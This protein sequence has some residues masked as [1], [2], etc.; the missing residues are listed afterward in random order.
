M[1]KVSLRLSLQTRFMISV[2]FLLVILVVSILFVIEQRERR[3]IFEDQKNKGVLIAKYIAQLNFERLVVF[4]DDE[5][6]KKN[7]ERQI[8]NNLIYVVVYDRNNKPFTGN[9]FIRNYEDIYQ[10]SNLTVDVKEED[11]Y[12]KRKKIKNRETG[13]IFRVLEIETPIFV[14]GS[15]KRWGSIKIGLSM[16]EMRAENQR[17]RLRMILIGCAGLLLGIMGANLL[18]RRITGP[19]KKLVEGTVKISKGNFSQ[20]IDI[21]SQ[22]EIGNLAQSFNKMSHQLLLTKRSIDAANKKLIQ[23]EKLASIGRLS[24]SI[25]HEIRNPLTSVKLNIQKVLESKQLNKIE[26]D[27]L[28]ISQEGIR[29]IETF[30]KELL[31]F[32]RVSELNL[33]FFS[34]EQIIDS[35]LKM[36]ADS[37]EMK[38]I[39]LEKDF[40]EK[41]PLIYVDGDKLRQV[42]LNI[43]RN[44]CEA[45]EERG[46]I[47]ISLSLEKDHSGKKIVIEISD[48]GCGIPAEDLE[49]IFEPFY[50]TKTSGIGL[51]LANARKIIESHEGTIKVK[52]QKGKGSTF[53]TIMPYKGE[54]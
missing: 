1:S 49:N 20:K 50:T 31:N 19:L 4:W 14:E 26:K 9:D 22:D 30:I 42:F 53:V 34:I 52:E 46:K 15:P 33:D 21:H 43:L 25:A 16:E 2:I 54:K 45:V 28:G 6:V 3:T 23:A 29:Q 18:A 17:T 7:I 27:H 8:D 36:M 44:A 11:Y 32:A 24:A 13:Q 38:K 35:S 48:D 10:K 37:L 47:K 39:R 51:G 5:G 12:F 41:L 40:P